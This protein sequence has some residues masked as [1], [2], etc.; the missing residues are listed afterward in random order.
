MWT[1]GTNGFFGCITRETPVAKNGFPA[2]SSAL[3]GRMSSPCAAGAAPG[4]ATGKLVPCTAEKLQPPFSNS[5]PRS[6][7]ISP[8]PPPG[9]S[10]AVRRN[11][12][13]PSTCSSFATMRSRRSRKRDSTS[14]RKA[15]MR[16][17]SLLLSGDGGAH[18]GGEVLRFLRQALAQRV[19]RE[20]A[21]L[22]VLADHRDGRV[23]LVLH[24]PLAIWIAEERLI[25]EDTTRPLEELFQLAG[26]DLLDHR[27][28]LAFVSELRAQRRLLLVEL[29]RRNVL[30]A[31]PFRIAPGDLHGHV[32]HQRLEL[33]V[34]GGEV[35]LA[36]DLN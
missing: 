36:V 11:F 32:L 4:G 16:P 7:A 34:A 19:A 20:A 18:F 14:A 31:H 29:C 17:A 15:S 1:M 6:S 13:P 26:D 2:I 21:H 10:Q 27:L 5:S 3:G 22:D 30:A 33:L 12:A 35:R 8:P 25:Q 23:N 28:R 9:R 24:G